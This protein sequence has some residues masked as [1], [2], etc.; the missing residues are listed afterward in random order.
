MGQYKRKIK[1]GV[2]YFYSGQYL[3]QKYFSK[4]I[5]LS[6]S[7]CATAE[8]EKLRE[9]D[10]K[11]RCG[12]NDK[13]IS[14]L[15]NEKLDEI[16]LNQS[17]AHY[18][19]SRR[20]YKM[21]LH[22]TGDVYVSEITK[23]QVNALLNKFSKDLKKRGKGNYNVNSMLRILKHLFYHAMNIHDVDMKNPCV[24]IKAYPIDKDL[25]YIPPDDEIEQ[26][27]NDLDDQERLLVQFLEETGARINE[28]LRLSDTDVYDDYIVLKTRKSRNSNLV[29]RKIPKPDCLMGIP[30]KGRLFER[31]AIY[32]RFLEKKV[33]SLGLRPWGFHNL[34][35][36][37]ASKLSKEGRPIFEIM[38]LLGHN[39]LSTTQNYLQLLP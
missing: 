14:E 35:H 13:L 7:E 20:Y 2:R 26:V 27:K 17:R 29:S 22:H 16:Q 6:K 30:F 31:W 32:P 34:R 24:G 39:N 9:L 12:S 11:A 19:E 33:Y 38:S 25:K 10:K 28:A 37:Y 5:Y 23:A 15:M 21:L 4:A 18:Q 3:G 1:K 8:R 36:R